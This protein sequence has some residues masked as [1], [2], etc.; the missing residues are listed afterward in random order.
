MCRPTAILNGCPDPA[1]LPNYSILKMKAA[2]TAEPSAPFYKTTPRDVP[3]DSTIQLAR[4]RSVSSSHQLYRKLP[5]FHYPEPTCVTWGQVLISENVKPNFIDT[6]RA[7]QTT[8]PSNLLTANDD[9][10]GRTAPL[11]SKCCILYIYSTNTG[12][13][14]FKHGIYSPIFPLQNAVCF[15]NLTYLVPLLFKFYIQG[16]LK[17]KKIIPALKG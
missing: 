10:S 1:L 9:Y 12:T 13:E 17:L 5:S 16:V 6:I 14:Y 7:E 2:G 11:T 4:A 3:A 8:A 15:I